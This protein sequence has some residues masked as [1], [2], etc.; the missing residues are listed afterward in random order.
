MSTWKWDAI[1]YSS[2]K[3]DEESLL[4][5]EAQKDS[6][7]KIDEPKTP[8][9][10]SNPADF[11]EDELEEMTLSTGTSM[12]NSPHR[13]PQSDHPKVHLSSGSEWDEEDEP[14]TEEDKQRHRKFVQM[15]AKHY[16]MK[17][18]FVRPSDIDD[19]DLDNDSM[20]DDDDDD[21][22]DTTDTNHRNKNQG[23]LNGSLSGTIRHHQFSSRQPI[24]S[25]PSAPNS[26]RTP[27]VRNGAP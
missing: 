25:S 22:D 20:G 17:E 26:S 23:M 11:L 4:L 2:L 18:A 16:N 27:P 6:K 21:S 15:R 7:M 5:T 9:V 3:W 24:P 8:F 19:D 1:Q 13:S 12:P 10:H 14:L